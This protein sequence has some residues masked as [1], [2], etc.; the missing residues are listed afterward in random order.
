M[1]FIVLSLVLLILGGVFW[2]LDCRY[3]TMNYVWR[4]SFGNGISSN[5]NS[6]EF[7]LCRYCKI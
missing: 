3:K 6:Q 7:S 1:L 5:P 4:D 2:F